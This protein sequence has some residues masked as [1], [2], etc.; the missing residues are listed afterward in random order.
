MFARAIFGREYR[1]HKF[2]YVRATFADERESMESAETVFHQSH[3]VPPYSLLAA[4][5]FFNGVVMNNM[6]IKIKTEKL[7]HSKIN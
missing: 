4:N 7:Q 5:F 1:S 3:T 6:I 2:T